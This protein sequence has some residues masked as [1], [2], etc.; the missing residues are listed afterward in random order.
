MFFTFKLTS[1]RTLIITSVVVVI[2]LVCGFI[3]AAANEIGVLCPD[4]TA[5]I[6]WLE[7]Q[8][9]FADTTPLWI[10]DVTVGSGD[11]WDNYATRFIS[12]DCSIIDLEG[13]R[14]TIH[15][16]MGVGEYADR[17]VRIVSIGERAVG[18]DVSNIHTVGQSDT[19]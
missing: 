17:F 15:C 9:V 11:G 10:R 12:S 14:A 2:M 4:D 3:R 8:G 5:R 18:Y 13:K 1:R 19:D 6:E 7:T 16:Y